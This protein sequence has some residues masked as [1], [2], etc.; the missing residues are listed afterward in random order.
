MLYFIKMAKTHHASAHGYWDIVYVR[1]LNMAY[2]L[3]A[4][5]LYVAFLTVYH[6]IY[7]C[8]IIIFI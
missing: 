4:I 3:S 5:G 6:V 8:Y 2:D 1:D 7:L